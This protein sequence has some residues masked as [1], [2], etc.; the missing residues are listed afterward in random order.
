MKSDHWKK[1]LLSLAAVPVMA[2]LAYGLTKDPKVI[3]SP[4]VGKVAP[5]FRLT[6]FNGE[7]VTL[8]DFRGK[9]VVINFWAAWCYPAC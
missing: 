8:S 9:V 2:L 1:I 5:P 4:L 3:P 7:D 6:L